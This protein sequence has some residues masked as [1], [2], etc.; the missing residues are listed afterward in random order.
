MLGYLQNI[1]RPD[2]SIDVH[3]YACFN[4]NPMLCHEKVVKYISRYLVS[5]QDKGIHYKPDIINGLE[6][7]VEAD[8]DGGWSTGDYDN[9]EC[10]LS[11]TVYVIMYAGCPLKW[12][13]NLQTEIVL[14]KTESEYIAL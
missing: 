6:C 7:Y 12:F 1:T 4:V 8:F 13:S 11:R 10:V 3:Q 14:S 2:I 9:P 5:T